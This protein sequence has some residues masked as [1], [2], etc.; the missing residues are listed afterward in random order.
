MDYDLNGYFICSRMTRS[1]TARASRGVHHMSKPT[2]SIALKL[3]RRGTSAFFK[4]KAMTEARPT[5]AQQ[6]AG[7]AIAFQREATGI[8]PESCTVLMGE[9]TLVVTLQDALSLAEK[10][11]ARTPEGAARVNEFHRRLFQASGGALHQELQRI[12]GVEISESS[13]EMEPG[14]GSFV[15]VFPSGALVQVFILAR[16]VSPGMWSTPKQIEKH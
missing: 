15:E 5:I 7:A 3:R 11:M 2:C 4:G 9:Q 1:R 13:V 8:S 10:Q 12:L 14:A 6:I 16:S